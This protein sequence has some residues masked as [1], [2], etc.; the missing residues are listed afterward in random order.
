MPAAACAPR[1]L[2]FAGTCCA[3]GM[4]LP[5]HSQQT[6]TEVPPSKVET[7][8]V[9]GS[10]IRGTPENAAL[11]VDVL[12]SDDL[13]LRGSP[14]NVDLI[15]SLPFIGA[16]FAG[17]A[18][19]LG[20]SRVQGAASVNLRGLGNART[21][22][23]LNG[24]RL[25]PITSGTQTLT[26]TN[27]L[28]MAAV[29]RVEVLKDGG[30]VTYGSDAIAGVVNFITYNEYR[31]TQVDATHSF[32]DGTDG[33][34][35]VA[36]KWGFGTDRVNVLVSAGYQHRSELSLTEREFAYRP[37]LENP[38]NW[39]TSDNPGIYSIGN[40]AA[41]AV[42]FVDPGCEAAGGELTPLPAVGTARTCLYHYTG[43]ENLVDEQDAF[44]LYGQVNADLTD[45][46][47]A[48]LRGSLFGNQCR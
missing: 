26:D 34:S 16:T 23:L 19:P 35:T 20:A 9:T 32:I 7:V 25:S 46:G 44:Q 41:T 15:K 45:N 1:Y 4:S 22:V 42:N 8:V 48:A 38:T 17:D 21:L 11:P 13:R 36:A 27:S 43:W 3:V 29:E 37:Y 2:A 33:D 40:S 10:I 5:A 31:G 6:D 12:S 28:P 47:V 14:S 24:R 39:S 30:A 18:N